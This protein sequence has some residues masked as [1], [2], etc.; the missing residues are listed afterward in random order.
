MLGFGFGVDIVVWFGSEGWRGHKSTERR[1]WMLGS[2]KAFCWVARA[3]RICYIR[4]RD[5]KVQKGDIKCR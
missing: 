2:G 4:L 5:V 3:W 1:C